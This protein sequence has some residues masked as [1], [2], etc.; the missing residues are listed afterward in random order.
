[1]KQIAGLLN[2]RYFSAGL[3][4]DYGEEHAFSDSLRAIRQQKQYKGDDILKYPGECD[5]S[6]YVNFK[7]LK[8]IVDG[9]EHL[10]HKGVIHQGFFLQFMGIEDR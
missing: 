8:Y 6:A 3:I 10:K 1:M 9:Y 2:S 4:I 7:A 5:L